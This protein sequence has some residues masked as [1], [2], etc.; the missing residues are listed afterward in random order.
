MGEGKVWKALNQTKIFSTYKRDP[1]MFNGNVSYSLEEDKS[2]VIAM[3]NQGAVWF[4]QE[5]KYRSKIKK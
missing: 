2:V 5:E 1:N 4:V 3:Y